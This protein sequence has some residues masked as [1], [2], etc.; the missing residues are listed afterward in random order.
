VNQAILARGHAVTAEVA[1]LGDRI[2]AWVADL[3]ADNAGLMLDAQ[4]H[5]EAALAAALNL[6][7]EV[8]ILSQVLAQDDAL[9]VAVV[10]APP[11]A[12]LDAGIRETVRA[13]WRAGFAPTDSGDGRKVGMA[14]ALDVPHV[15]LRCDPAL[16]VAESS[17]LHELVT[18]WGL[19]AVDAAGVPTIQASY[20]PADGVAVLMLCGV[21]DDMLPPAARAA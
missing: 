17:R 4:M 19:A 6:R 10:P 5:S 18:S 8:S 2:R 7:T 13:L 12:E 21:C 11:W 16:L 20:A 1:V 9:A 15:F 14:C 3:P